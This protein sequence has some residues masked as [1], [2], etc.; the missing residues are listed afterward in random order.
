MSSLDADNSPA[1][2]LDLPAR[3]KSG[4]IMS[5][6]WNKAASSLLDEDKK[7][8]PIFKVWTQH[9]AHCFSVEV[10]NIALEGDIF[11]SW[12]EKDKNS[13]TFPLRYPT[14]SP[15]AATLHQFFAGQQL[16]HLK[17]PFLAHS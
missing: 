2:D 14:E 5:V 10:A 6:G 9:L 11:T 3:N 13:S 17:A 7:Q 12:P 16:L 1:W 15:N 8:G 4:A